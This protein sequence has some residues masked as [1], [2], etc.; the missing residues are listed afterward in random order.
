MD[1]IATVVAEDARVE[2]WSFLERRDVLEDMLPRGLYVR[3]AL[4]PARVQKIKVGREASEAAVAAGVPID[5]ESIRSL[6][7]IA[8]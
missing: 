6:F 2:V 8:P 5:P 3:Y 1:S 4:E 7:K